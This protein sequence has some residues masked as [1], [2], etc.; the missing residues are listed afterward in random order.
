MG[1]AAQRKAALDNMIAVM[2]K[3]D[4]NEASTGYTQGWDIVVSYSEKEINENLKRKWEQSRAV[5]NMTSELSL[6]IC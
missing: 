4:T 5:S 3:K 2:A 1:D 6:S